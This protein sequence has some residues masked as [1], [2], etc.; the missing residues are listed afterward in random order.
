MT[1]PEQQ[2]VVDLLWS[3]PDDS[4]PGVKPHTE[5]DPKGIKN[6]VKYGPDRVIQFLQ[7]NGFSKIIRSHESVIG[8][9]A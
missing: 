2:M 1:T 9:F 6:I 4:I 7:L 5:R 3:D 8:G